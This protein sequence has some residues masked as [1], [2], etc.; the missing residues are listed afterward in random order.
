MIRVYWDL[1]GTL[2]KWRT[3]ATT[4][5]LYKKNY[6]LSLDPEKELCDLANKLSKENEVDSYILTSFLEDSEYAKTEKLAWVKNHISELP[7]GNILCVPYGI[8]KSSFVEDIEHKELSKTDVLIDDHSPNLIAWE[9]AGGTAI[10]WC[11][12]INDSRKSKFAGPRFKHVGQ[13]S[14]L[15]KHM[16]GFDA[17]ESLL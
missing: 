16:C 8:R 10:K 9:Q 12:G 13:L 5:D 3:A 15:L 1:D 7:N 17:K 4:A 14:R 2:A 11:N 6:F